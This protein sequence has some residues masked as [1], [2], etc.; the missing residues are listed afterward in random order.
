MFRSS[1]RLLR[2][3]PADGLQVMVRGR[4]T[5]YEDRGELQI[6]A[7]SIEPKGAGSLQLAFEQLKA[8]LAAEGLF[9]PE[10]KK[11][12]PSLPRA[13]GSSLCSGRRIARYSQHP[14]AASSLRE[15]PHFPRA[16]A[17]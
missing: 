5:I 15:R 17:G 8:K 16:G 11:P 10:R 13:S 9:A 3:R 1:A 14:P 2:F 4:V 7:E 6:S 12:I